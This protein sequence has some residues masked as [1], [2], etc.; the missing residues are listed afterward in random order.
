[1]ETHPSSTAFRLH[2]G[3]RDP[4]D[5]ARGRQAPARAI[6]RP[7][8][9]APKPRAT[10]ATHQP[11]LSFYVQPACHFV[12]RVDCQKIRHTLESVLAITMTAVSWLTQNCVARC[13]DRVP[14][15]RMWARWRSSPSR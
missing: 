2:S 4:D 9:P 7:A 8:Q 6:T 3:A 14:A 10:L 1:M 13:L 11:S 12:K 15:L 5:G